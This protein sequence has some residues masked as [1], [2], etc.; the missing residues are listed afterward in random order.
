MISDR[1]LGNGAKHLVFAFFFRGGLE[2]HHKHVLY[3]PATLIASGN[4]VLS[5]DLLAW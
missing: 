4:R 5:L 1:Q 3:R 2:A